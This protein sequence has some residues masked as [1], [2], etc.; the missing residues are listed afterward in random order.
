MKRLALVLPLLLAA[1]ALPQDSVPGVVTVELETLKSK[2]LAVQVK[3]NGKGPFRLIF[4]TGAP[5]TL[6]SNRVAKDAGLEAPRGLMGMGGEVAVESFE[7]G[8]AKAEGT[9]VMVFDHPTVQR[10]AKAVGD[11]DG[12]VGFSF[13]AQFETTIDYQARKLTLIPIGYK[14]VPLM[15]RLQRMIG[16]GRRDPA[17]AVISRP[18]LLGL[19]LE[20]ETSVVKSV[21]PGG[22]AEAAGLTSGDKITGFDGRWIE[23]ARDLLDAVRLLA[24]GESVPVRVARD[25]KE[26]ELNI[27]TRSGV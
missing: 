1:P 15:E 7:V 3:V 6:I 2:H 16:G 23:N 24:P 21:A 8:A 4:D 12:I 25:G 13:F 14:P 26:I 22:S 20:G 18:V 9:K 10:L 11:L 5:V 19:E 17:R 27:R